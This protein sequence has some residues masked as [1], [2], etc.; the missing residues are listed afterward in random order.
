MTAHHLVVGLTV[1]NLAA[2]AL[3]L[4]RGGQAARASAPE[5]LRAHVIELVDR[6]GRVRAQL[7][8]E[9]DG[10]AIF[11][12]RDSTGE[13]RVKIGAGGDGSGLVLLD[14]STE[15]GIQMLA[16]RAATSLTLWGNDGR[17]RVITP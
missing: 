1:V 3:G 14:G 15:P 9:D 8:V 2:L 17:R 4:G 7:K 16:K 5:T 12:L 10:E 13:V 6:E 11:R